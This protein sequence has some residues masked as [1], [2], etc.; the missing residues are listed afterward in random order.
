[1]P[2]PKPAGG[3]RGSSLEPGCRIPL[4]PSSSPATYYGRINR[5]QAS[6]SPDLEPRSACRDWLMSGQTDLPAAERN[7]PGPG[8][9]PQVIRV[10]GDLRFHTDGDLIALAFTS[11]DILWSVEEPGVLRQWNMTA[12]QP[13]GSHF[14]SDL[15]PLWHFGP[16]PRVLVSGSDEV[17]LW[18]M[19]T[20]HLL[21]TVSPP[22]WVTAVALWNHPAVL[23]TGHDEG[24]VRLWDA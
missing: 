23:A 6:P 13:L 15:E 9:F 11:P 3:P 16:D 24:V 22:S 14:P 2:F 8:A 20:G 10:F 18:D 4:L 1:G 19:A 5:K 7:F 21:A 12:G 17:S